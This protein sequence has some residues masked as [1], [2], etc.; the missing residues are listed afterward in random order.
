MGTALFL[1]GR[2]RFDRANRERDHDLCLGG[3]ADF[4]LLMRE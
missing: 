4:S 2:R 3:R 1:Y